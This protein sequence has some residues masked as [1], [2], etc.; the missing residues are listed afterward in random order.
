MRSKR[1][2]CAWLLFYCLGLC[3][4]AQAQEVR[5]AT[6][7]ATSHCPSDMVEID[8]RFCIDRY[9]YPNQE[10][11]IPLGWVTWLEAVAKCRVQGK[12]L[13]SS[14]EWQRACAGPEG[15][16]YPYGNSY[17]RKTC[18]SGRKHYRTAAASGSL[19]ECKSPEGVFD[20]S[21]NL[22][23]WVGQRP[24][25]AALAGGA[26]L[27]DGANSKCASR[28]WT[29]VPRSKNFVYGFRCCLNLKEQK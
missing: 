14:D 15:R 23:E 22:W 18:F 7:A 13:C 6:E 28:A 25:E 10:G 3:C 20:L 2:L 16:V 9:E 11:K 4:A 24:E 8:G 5:S 27:T 1:W 12:R 21:G 17:N 19:A 29:G 26:W